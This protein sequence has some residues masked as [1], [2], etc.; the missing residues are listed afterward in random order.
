MTR[1]MILAAGLALLAVPMATAQPGPA[2]GAGPGGR[3][4]ERMFQQLDT[5]SD[6]RVT[7]EEALGWVASRFQQ[8]DT[9]RDGA[10]SLAEFQAVRAGTRPNA[11]PNA[12]P[13]TGPKPNPNPETGLARS[14]ERRAAM[15]RALDANA[16]GRLTL[17][18][19]RPAVE[20]RF[21]AADANS[22]GVVTRE[23]L[24][25]RQAQRGPAHRDGPPAAR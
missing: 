2:Q 9:D 24:P 4:P 7:R 10:L 8:A 16:D 6:G 21:R 25:Q 11:S 17:E 13:N 5:N 19:V 20:A 23:E 15:F 3:G 12:S 22:D 18:E 1:T 14:G